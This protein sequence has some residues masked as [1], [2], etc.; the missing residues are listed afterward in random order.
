MNTSIFYTGNS[1]IVLRLSLTKDS[2]FISDYSANNNSTQSSFIVYTQGSINYSNADGSF[3]LT[4][5]V[6]DTTDTTVAFDIPSYLAMETDDD[7]AEFFCISKYNHVPV[8]RAS[9]QLEANQQH[10]GNTDIVFLATGAVNIAGVETT[11]PA[12][13][14]N[15][16]GT[17]IIATEPTWIIELS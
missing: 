15:T 14:E 5:T 8:I 17:N 1:F 3:K 6:G 12:V 10:Q 9:Y 16:L 4:R 11:A 2:A 13:L 7:T